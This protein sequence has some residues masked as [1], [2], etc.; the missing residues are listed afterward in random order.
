MLNLLAFFFLAVLV[1]VFSIRFA[2]ALSNRQWMNSEVDNNQM[3]QY[4]NSKNHSITLA[5]FT[6]AAIALVTSNQSISESVNLQLGITFL[7][8]AMFSF[9]IGSY[10]FGFLSR[11]QWFPYIG[12]TLE[13]VGILALAIGLFYIIIGLFQA[14]LSLQILYFSFFAALIAV[15][16]YELLLTRREL[17]ASRDRR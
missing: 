4:R 3:E 12:E 10:M 14:S 9:F 13:F 6:I 1:S 5:A 15:T 17:N 2:T 11:Q 16:G 7:S 8:G